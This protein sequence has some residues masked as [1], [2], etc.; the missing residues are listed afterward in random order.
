MPFQPTPDDDSTDAFDLRRELLDA[1]EGEYRDHLTAMRAIMEAGAVSGAALRDVFRRAH[2]LKGAAR[3]VDLPH[4]EQIAHDL[5]TL[6]FAAVEA[7]R[8]L[9][10]EDVAT[11]RRGLDAIEADMRGERGPEGAADAETADTASVSETVPAPAAGAAPSTAP[12]AG[13]RVSSQ[14][15]DRLVESVQAASDTMLGQEQDRQWLLDHR[16]ALQR[17][18]LL[19]DG[20]SA[21]PANG[22]EIA[23]GIHALLRA[24]GARLR[25]S[26]YEDWQREQTVSALRAQVERVALVSAESV[27]GPLAAMARALGRERDA[28]IAVRF[29]GLELRADRPVLQALRDPVIQL[30]RNALAHGLARRLAEGGDGDQPGLFLGVSIRAGRLLVEV[31]DNGDGPDLAAI[32]ARARA[33]G[34]LPAH[35]AIPDEATVLALCF[36]PGF[37]TASEVDRLSGRGMGLSIVAEAAR[38]LGGTASMHVRRD[39]VGAPCGT[40]ICLSVPLSARRQTLVLLEAGGHLLALPSDAVMRLHRLPSDAIERDG[41]ELLARIAGDAPKPVRLLSSLLGLEAAPLAGGDALLVV[42]KAEGGE[43]V[44]LVDGLRAVRTAVVRP[45]AIVGIDRALAG[46][47]ALLDD[48]RPVVVLEPEGL[49]NAWARSKGDGSTGSAQA[50]V[51]P[52]AARRRHTILVV[53]DSIT[54]RTLEKTILQAQG[55]AVLI[56]VDGLEALEVLRSA[57]Q[58]ID[59]VVAD[60]EM[61]R[62]DGFGLVAA[63]QADPSLKAMPVVLMTSRDDP[64][65]IRRGLELGASAYLTKQEFEQGT[66][67]SVIRQVLP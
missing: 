67:L 29:E 56:A 40:R 12:D 59:V 51:P 65:D 57:E 41:A 63:M 39:A 28:E 35:A 61:P 27:F 33:Q 26:R 3:A 50:I 45:P 49:L 22:A 14:D 62:L 19:C 21:K 32:A 2:S 23:E 46:G 20:I 37:S 18:L 11:V 4:I 15:I 10:P 43:A 6:L 64:A 52:G 47:V 30:L 60:V 34:L 13:S 54:T 25:Q 7:A 8:A 55:Y 31:S 17:L 16:D 24:T 48:N 5:E 9:P 66:L 42:M 1:F 38:R 53:D 44:L 36:E 58:E